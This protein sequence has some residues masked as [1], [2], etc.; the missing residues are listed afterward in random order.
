MK[1]SQKHWLAVAFFVI[2]MVVMEIILE[3]P[4]FGAS[5][6][7]K[8]KEAISFM[9]DDEIVDDILWD[10]DNDFAVVKRCEDRVFVW[11]ADSEGHLEAVYILTLDEHKYILRYATQKMLD[12]KTEK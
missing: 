9:L 12:Q 10:I 5:Y 8:D 4:A 11:Y 3:C 2:L 6:Q 7:R 1:F